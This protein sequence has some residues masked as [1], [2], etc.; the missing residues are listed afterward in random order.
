M[1]VYFGQIYIEPGVTFPFSIAFK[2]RLGEEVS[3]LIRPSSKFI[4]CYGADWNLVFRISAKRSIADSEIRGPSVF[5][6]QRNLE[7]TIFLP[8]DAIQGAATPLH[9]AIELL[10]RGVCAVLDTLGFDTNSIQA[11][12]GTLATSLSSDPTMLEP[13]R[14]SA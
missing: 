11:R 8:F 3:A 5:K 1:K 12:E 9:S 4:Q 7:F 10:L 14:P 2:R 6:K 13:N